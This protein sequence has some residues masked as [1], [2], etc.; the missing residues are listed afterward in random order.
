[1]STEV[2]PMTAIGT[3]AANVHP[4]R[5]FPACADDVAGRLDAAFRGAI[6]AVDERE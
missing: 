2:D 3:A 6:K 5:C 4:T 1:L